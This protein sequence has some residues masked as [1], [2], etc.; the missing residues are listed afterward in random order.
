M[1]DQIA[2]GEQADDL[3]E[4]ANG[5]IEQADRLLK[6]G[7]YHGRIGN[8]RAAA[9]ALKATAMYLRGVVDVDAKYQAVPFLRT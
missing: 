3:E 7:A 2:L 6:V 1:P 8:R 9:Q 5:L 4:L